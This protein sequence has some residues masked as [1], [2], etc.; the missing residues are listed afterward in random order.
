MLNLRKTHILA[1]T[2]VKRVFL[3]I[4]ATQIILTA[5]L[6]HLNS[7]WR[8][9]SR[10]V[11]KCIFAWTNPN[12]L[13]LLV[14]N[15]L[16]PN[17]LLMTFSDLPCLSQLFDC[18]V[19]RNHFLILVKIHQIASFIPFV[20]FM[21]YHS[22]ITCFSFEICI[23]TPHY[24]LLLH[25]SSFW[26]V[27][28]AHKGLRIAIFGPQIGAVFLLFAV[29]IHKVAP[30]NWPHFVFLRNDL[31]WIHHILHHF[32]FKVASSFQIN[33]DSSRRVLLLLDGLIL[34]A[35]RK[36][37]LDYWSSVNKLLLLATSRFNVMNS[38]LHTRNYLLDFLDILFDLQI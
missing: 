1:K 26:L 21:D 25:S 17:R 2:V 18:L 10:M 38:F 28:N 11:W 24:L 32:S 13:L 12:L 6:E 36:S 15:L 9:L 33:W 35:R 14:M 4:I 3:L 22:R 27:W 19:F 8:M 16:S 34:A 7:F 5:H 31:H 30:W 20:L 23:G 37:L 29:R